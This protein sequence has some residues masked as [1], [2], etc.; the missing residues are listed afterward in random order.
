MFLYTNAPHTQTPC[1]HVHTVNVPIS[2][3]AKPIAHMPTE[4]TTNSKT[5]KYAYHTHSHRYKHKQNISHLVANN[6]VERR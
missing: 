2:T 1:K 5:H 3:H 6:M 4:R